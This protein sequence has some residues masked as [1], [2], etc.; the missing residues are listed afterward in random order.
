MTRFKVR[1]LKP[2][3]TQWLTID[4]ES[5]ADA[6]MK[7]HERMGRTSSI[8]YTPDHERPGAV[9]WFAL[10]EVAGHGEVVS[11][12][13]WRGIARR[14]GVRVRPPTTLADVATALGWPH[15]TDDLVAP[16]WEGED[17]KWT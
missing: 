1:L 13:Y 7:L 8:V 9:I 6:V 3:P 16:G 14:G 10:A 15:A 5:T 2:A 4:A 11:R 17:D 12:L